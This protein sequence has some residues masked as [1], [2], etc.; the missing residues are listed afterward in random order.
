MNVRKPYSSLDK[1]LDL[2]E[3]CDELVDVWL[4]ISSSISALLAI[5]SF[6]R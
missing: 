5:K 3:D 2:N 1:T 6:R 4:E